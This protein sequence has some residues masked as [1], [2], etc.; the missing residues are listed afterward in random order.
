[1]SRKFGEDDI[2]TQKNVKVII[3]AFLTMGGLLGKGSVY[4]DTDFVSSR[5]FQ[6]KQRWEPETF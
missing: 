5:M 4:C 1:M 3:V 6:R 2:K